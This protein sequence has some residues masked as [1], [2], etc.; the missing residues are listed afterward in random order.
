VCERSAWCT[1]LGLGPAGGQPCRTPSSPARGCTSCLNCL[2]RTAPARTPA[3]CFSMAEGA[4]EEMPEEMGSFLDEVASVLA[5]SA[6]PCPSCAA[7]VQRRILQVHGIINLAEGTL[8]AQ[9]RLGHGLWVQGGRLTPAGARRSSAR[10]A[11]FRARTPLSRGT[12][13]RTRPSAAPSSSTAS[14]PG[15]LAPSS[16]CGVARDSCLAC[17]LSLPLSLSLFPATHVG[18][19]Q[20]RTTTFSIPEIGLE[21]A[22]TDAVASNISVE[23]LLLATRAEV[24]PGP[25][26]G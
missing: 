25:C 3:S 12:S 13:C 26:H 23:Q 15:A 8:L 7:A 14:R 22:H 6:A 19:V 21:S 10:P 17:C 24:W 9:A 18:G 2:H 11:A 4:A 5:I 1:G 20:S 16:R